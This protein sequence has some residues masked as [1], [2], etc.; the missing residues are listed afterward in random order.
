MGFQE[1]KVILKSCRLELGLRENM[2]TERLGTI[3]NLVF[4]IF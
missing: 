1:K 4:G 2:S 3:A